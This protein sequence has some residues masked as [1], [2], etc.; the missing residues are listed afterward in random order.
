[1]RER[2]AFAFS[3]TDRNHYP[4]P[5]F[6]PGCRTTTPVMKKISQGK[7]SMPSTM[8]FPVRD[9]PSG[10]KRMSKFVDKSHRGHAEITEDE[11]DFCLLLA[12]C[13]RKSAPIFSFDS[14]MR[15][16]GHRSG[17]VG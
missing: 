8:V 9:M 15:G 17:G 12:C 14:R 7:Y 13:I 11:E 16:L 10:S 2:F 5:T 3:P 6:S 1:M 4:Q